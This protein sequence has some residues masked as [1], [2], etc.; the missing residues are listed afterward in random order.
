MVLPF[1]LFPAVCRTL[2]LHCLC[3]SLSINLDNGGI[4]RPDNGGLTGMKTSLQLV[5]YSN[6][7]PVYEEA[8]AMLMF[9][10]LLISN[11]DSLVLCL[12]LSP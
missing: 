5:L 12:L 3:G 4:V 2:P 9:G 7:S 8:Y 11:Q 6:H 1:R 10:F